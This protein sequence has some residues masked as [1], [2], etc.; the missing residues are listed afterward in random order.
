MTNSV[1]MGSKKV[2]KSE[3]YRTRVSERV[4]PTQ[5]EKNIINLLLMSISCI[6]FLRGFFDES[7]FT[8]DSFEIPKTASFV[9]SG[10]NYPPSNKKDFIKIKRLAPGVADLSDVILNWINV[11]AYDALH[12]GYLRAINLSIVLD[13]TKPTIIHE[14]YNFYI[15]YLYS[16]IEPTH[17][18]SENLLSPAELTKIQTFKLLKKFILTI[19][20]LKALPT[21]RFLLMRLMLN[22]KCPKPYLV[23]HF[24]DCSKKK[25]ETLKLPLD[26]YEDLTTNCG[27]VQTVHHTLE[28][29]IA[30]LSSTNSVNNV[31]NQQI[32]IDPFDIFNNATLNQDNKESQVSQISKEFFDVIQDQDKTLHDGLTQIPN[33]QNII[34]DDSIN[35]TVECTCKSHEYLSY[36]SI[37]QCKTCKKGMHKVCYP[38]NSDLSSFVCMD[39]Q[40][41]HKINS[42]DQFI[43]F[44]IRKLIT[45]LQQNRH[46]SLT[47]IKATALILGYTERDLKR[48]DYILKNV[49]NVFS[50]L[51]YEGLI[52]LKNHKS[53]SHNLFKVDVNGLIINSATIKQ[54]RYFIAFYIKNNQDKIDKY[55]DPFFGIE[56]RIDSI[57]DNL[58]EYANETTIVEDCYGNIGA[59]KHISNSMEIFEE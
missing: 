33:T 35:F 20:S 1:T 56:E 46:D 9:T 14:S 58:S 15:E 24:V 4:T 51:I 34:E 3:G 45:F 49:A 25:T 43:L 40:N 41:G 19:Q 11:S 32:E 48:N 31:T 38:I 29:S 59:R 2:R 36:S 27:S 39:C 50:I 13:E 53:F 22:D 6:A 54:G 23:E 7:Y 30:S 28:I 17:F 21:K 52:S 47:S 5:S 18:N 12:K 26:Q 57:I 10:E 16:T 8:D 44:N 55:F 37:L 42:T